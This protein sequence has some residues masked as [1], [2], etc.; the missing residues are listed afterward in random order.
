[1]N[2][3]CYQ[4]GTTYQFDESTTRSREDRCF[5]SAP[6]KAA[7]ARSQGAT[8]KHVPLD[9]LKSKACEYCGTQ[10]WF[11]AYAERGG[12]RVPTYCCASCRKKAW[13]NGQADKKRR[14][15]NARQNERSWD[16]FHERAQQAE[17][18]RKQ[19]HGSFDT[20]SAL[21]VPRHWD[22]ITATMWLH[23]P[24]NATEAECIKAYRKIVSQHHPDKNNGVEWPYLKYVN[25][26]YDH[27]KRKW[28]ARR[29]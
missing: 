22:T 1:M 13:S 25:A 20:W 23:V 21:K 24:H 14:A 3:K 6:C 8:G 18:E 10:F 5:C 17:R 15:D 4:C 16:A 11:N 29:S 19:A 27:L 26:A 7:Y 12:K 2:T 28:K 9:R